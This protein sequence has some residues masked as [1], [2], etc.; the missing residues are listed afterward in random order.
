[1]PVPDSGRAH[2]YGFS[3]ASGIPLVEG[4]MK[5]RYIA[6]TFIM[7]EQGMREKKVRLKTNPIKSVI[8]GKKIV[9]IDDSLVRG[10]TMR[11]IVDSLCS[12]GVKEVHVRIGSPPIIAP[13]YF[14]IDMSTREQL[15]AYA[16]NIDDICRSI[17]ADSLG[18]SSI[19]GIC[20]SL[21]IKRE[22]LC[23]GCVTGAYPVSIPGEK[24]R[25]QKNLKT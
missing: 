7:P 18:Y 19:D 24:H 1:V 21:K 13:C 22:D 12:A 25:F 4:L 10:T 3:S 6:R 9:L 15:M 20:E 11:Q 16:K 5:N 8:N 17:H 2:A 23:L 14:G